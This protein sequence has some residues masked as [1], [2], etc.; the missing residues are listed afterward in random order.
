MLV[1]CRRRCVTTALSRANSS[2]WLRSSWTAPVP[3]QHDPTARIRCPPLQLDQIRCIANVKQAGGRTRTYSQQSLELLANQ[4]QSLCQSNSTGA[5]ELSTLLEKA[6]EELLG[7]TLT[8]R[9]AECKSLQLGGKTLLWLRKKKEETGSN[10]VLEA[11]FADTLCWFLL[12]EDSEDYVWEWIHAEIT[13]LD[14]RRYGANM[15]WSL[16]LLAGLS[17]AHW[18]CTEN[19]SP[20][21]SILCFKRAIETLP[22]DRSGR[23]VPLQGLW[24]TINRM[25]YCKACPVHSSE[26]F[27]YFVDQTHLAHDRKGPTRQKEAR[28]ELFRPSEPKAWALLQWLEEGG[29][30]SSK[31]L[32][33]RAPRRNSLGSDLL[34]ACYILKHQGHTAQAERLLSMTKAN[35]PVVCSPRVYAQIMRDMENDRRLDGIRQAH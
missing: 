6:K 25:I 1:Q 5:D 9:R 30:Q 4:L 11:H 13:M 14:G 21:P 18:L 19:G 24:T 10:T 23:L 7:A 22:R 16:R 31:I 33:S 27:D 20:D 3:H 29:L 17:K 8:D 34:R 35:F 28:L 15:D 32:S 12:A 26:L 2:R